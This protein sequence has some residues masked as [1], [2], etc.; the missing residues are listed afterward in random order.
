MRKIVAPVMT[1]FRDKEGRMAAFL[2]FAML[3]PPC[4]VEVSAVIFMVEVERVIQATM[5]SLQMGHAREVLQ[6]RRSMLGSMLS[7]IL[8]AV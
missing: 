2:S 1:A 5:R 6:G 7:R 4:L 8:L 3:L